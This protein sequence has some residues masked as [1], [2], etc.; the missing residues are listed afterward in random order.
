MSAA[1]RVELGSRDVLVYKGKLIDRSILDAIVDNPDKRLL[2]AFVLND[3]GDIRCFPYSEER[4]I[5]RSALC[6][7]TRDIT[8]PGGS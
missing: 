5:W 6:Y 4:V 1:N 8:G 3:Y 2:W 7:A